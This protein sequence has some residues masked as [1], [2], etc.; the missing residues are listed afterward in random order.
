MKR[1]FGIL[2]VASLWSGFAFSQGPGE[3]VPNVVMAPVGKVQV[4]A[5]STANV[6]LDFRIGS[7]FHINSNKPKSELLIPTVLKLSATQPVRLA[8]LKY[9]AGHD[10]SFPF[11]PTESLS[12]YSGDFSVTA[13]VAAPSKATKGNYAVTGELRFQACDRSACY[14]PRSIPGEVRS[15]GY[16]PITGIRSWRL[17]IP[18]KRTAQEAQRIQTGSGIT[19]SCAYSAALLFKCGVCVGWKSRQVRDR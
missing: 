7:E 8:A 15:F 17:F 16:Q 18:T 10:M 11:A 19:V 13:V 5:G 6:E 4:K 12:V 1:I 14:P 2:L 9:P 3:K